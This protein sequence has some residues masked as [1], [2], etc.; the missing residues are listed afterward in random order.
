MIN[1]T[2]CVLILISLMVASSSLMSTVQFGLAQTGTQ[3]IGIITSDA[4]WT[5]ANSP[6]ELTGLAA[7]NVGVTLT[8]EPGVVVNLNGF[9]I[10]V[11]GTLIARG[12]AAE[13]INFNSGQIIITSLAKGWNAQTGSGCIFEN[14]N[15]NAAS[16]SSDVPLK[17]TN[18]YSNAT[19]TA[20]NSTMIAFSLLTNDTAVGDSSTV[21]DNTM[22]GKITAG[23]LSTITNN[24]VNGDI[25]SGSA[26]IQNNT[27]TGA[28]AIRNTIPQ[29]SVISNNTLAGGGS[30][31]E[32]L[33]FVPG[34]IPRNARY[35]RSVVD[36]A[37]G[38][39]AIWNNTI[40]SQDISAQEYGIQVPQSVFDGGYG[41]TTQGD[42]NADIHDNIILG[43]FVRGINLIGPGTI[44]NNLIVNNSG[45]IAIGKK[46]YDYGM[47]I[48]QGD[49]TIRDNILAN[50]GVGMSGFVLNGYFGS[51]DYDNAPKTRT[52][53]IEGNV[54][55]T[56]TSGIDFSL[57]MATL[58]IINNTIA[59]SSIAIALTS[60]PS[61]T[62]NF[63][64]IQNYTLRSINLTSTPANI[65]ATYNWWGT[66]S[67]ASI[68]QSIYDFYDDFNLG[69]VE[70]LPIL[71]ES[72]PAAPVPPRDIV[73]PELP[74]WTILLLLMTA[75][76]LSAI[77][78]RRRRATH[79][80]P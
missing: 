18:T 54:I 30:V 20:A 41:I 65:N 25:I 63:N 31:W 35:P 43:G 50:N 68:N 29:G 59:N 64:N 70:F 8:I 23:N 53:T 22:T 66:T 7:V 45:G 24:N 12:T 38:T 33:L 56:S 40:T 73:I 69:I 79:W 39:V 47:L 13:K 78:V 10:R 58:N 28:I 46:V 52:V 16:I 49:A 57:P 26:S 27:I 4:I 44:R 77:M 48:S 51:V 67:T 34:L 37:G 55:A 14:A 3:V 15:L 42:C 36:A 19:I 62:I 5:K 61:A 21:T 1:K 9:Y 17:I 2:A 72:N 80:F 75:T 11:N 60:C 6:Y 74:S 76:V 32:F 71:N